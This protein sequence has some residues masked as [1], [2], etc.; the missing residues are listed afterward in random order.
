MFQKQKFRPGEKIYQE[1][2][3]TEHV[4]LI[5]KGCVELTKKYLTSQKQVLKVRIAQL[6]V[7]EFLGEDDL[8]LERGRKYNAVAF[9]NCTLLIAQKK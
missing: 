6:G 7:G 3:E 8:I 1:G 4:Y 9:D 5:K 2:D